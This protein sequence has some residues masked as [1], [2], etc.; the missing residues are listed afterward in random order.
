MCTP[1][2]PDVG[3]NLW[4]ELASLRGEPGPRPPGP[5]IERSLERHLARSQRE[6]ARRL[7]R[8]AAA[9]AGRVFPLP[10]RGVVED[11]A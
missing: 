5:W 1:R 6:L 10:R 3:P 11:Q 4:R 7:D 8:M 9:A 2:D